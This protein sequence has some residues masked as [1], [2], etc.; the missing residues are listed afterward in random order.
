MSFLG[1]P[2]ANSITLFPGA[3]AVV[4]GSGFNIL[5]NGGPLLITRE[6]HGDLVQQE[7]SAISVTATGYVGVNETFEM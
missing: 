3:T 1:P 5:P 7:W 6:T 4:S 2:L